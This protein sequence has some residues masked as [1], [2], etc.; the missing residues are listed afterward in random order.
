M[1]KGGHRHAPFP[2]MDLF[3]DDLNVLCLPALRAF[4]NV[5]LD[6]LAFL[7]RTETIALNRREVNENVFSVV[8]AQK[9]KTLCIVEPLNYTLFHNLI[10][11]LL[12]DVP[13][14]AMWIVCE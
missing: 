9:T 3:S 10:L 13:L 2:V 1:E 4:D 5:E 12:P 7:E 8:T 6:G 14:N 11:N